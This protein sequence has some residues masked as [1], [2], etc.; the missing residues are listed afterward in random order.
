MTHIHRLECCA[1]HRH[2]G[3]SAGPPPAHV[4]CHLC[5]SDSV[6]YLRDKAE[7]PLHRIGFGL[8]MLH[9]RIPISTPDTETHRSRF[10]ELHK[11]IL[12]IE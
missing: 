11:A 10:Q 9:A 6:D 8:A 3:A 2:I 7:V 5:F 1:C 12:R 4:F